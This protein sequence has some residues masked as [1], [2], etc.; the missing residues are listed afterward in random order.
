MK[1]GPEH[2]LSVR[3]LRFSTVFKLDLIVRSPVLAV[4]YLTFDI[5]PSLQ[6][7]Y[8]H[9]TL[10]SP[11]YSLNV[12]MK[13]YFQVALFVSAHFALTLARTPC[14]FVQA[15]LMFSEERTLFKPDLQQW[16]PL[17]FPADCSQT[18]ILIK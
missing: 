13:Y 17:K 9:L 18:V 4:I 2:G 10:I 5:S 14:T 15:A 3:Y 1:L 6:S 7:S 12:M 16:D 8:P 11:R